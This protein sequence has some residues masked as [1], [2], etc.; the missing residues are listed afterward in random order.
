MDGRFAGLRPFQQYFSHIRTMGTQ[1]DVGS[2]VVSMTSY[3]PLPCGFKSHWRGN[4]KQILL[5]YMNGWL[6][7]ETIRD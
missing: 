1:I 5:L 6:S 3:I 2:E 4:K 7:P